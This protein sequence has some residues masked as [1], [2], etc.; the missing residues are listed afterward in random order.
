MKMLF[1]SLGIALLSFSAS[2]QSTSGVLSFYAYSESK[3]NALIIKLF[4]GGDTPAVGQ[5]VE[6]SKEFTTKL[7]G[8]DVKGT[9]GLAK[10]TIQSITTKELIIN[11]SEWT[12]TIVEDEVKRPMA[13]IGDTMLVKW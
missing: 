10:G 8:A 2:A 4:A 3:D 1:F 6:V 5:T 9:H 12:G 11:V 7:F 13:K